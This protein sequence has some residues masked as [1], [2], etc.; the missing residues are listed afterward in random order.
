MSLPKI[1]EVKEELHYLRKL[2][3]PSTGFI[4]PRIKMLIKIKKSEKG[5]SKRDLAEL[6]GV[7]IT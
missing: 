4:A 1:I 2:L 6:V 5:I 7:K 3:K